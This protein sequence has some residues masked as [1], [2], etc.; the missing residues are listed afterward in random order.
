MGHRYSYDDFTTK[1]H[2]VIDYGD[3]R[4]KD[5]VKVYELGGGVSPE[6]KLIKTVSHVDQ[7]SST[8]R[9]LSPERKRELIDGL[10]RLKVARI[11][12]TVVVR[13]R[14]GKIEIYRRPPKRKGRKRKATRGSS[15][16]PEE[17]YNQL[18]KV[19]LRAMKKK[20][21]K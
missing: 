17:L 2:G 9:N 7:V 1:G 11:G 15:S 16:S 10:K 13:Y 19:H 12:K 3:G 4:D 20:R 8:I 18:M 14:S 6:H 5:L 21:L